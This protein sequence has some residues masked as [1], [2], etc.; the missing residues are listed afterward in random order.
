[1]LADMVG[2]GLGV[3]DADTLIV[4]DGEID[5]FINAEMRTDGDSDDDWGP[6]TLAEKDTDAATVGDAEAERDSD[7]VAVS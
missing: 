3:I 4:G 5:G 6:D 1:M 2:D 7:D